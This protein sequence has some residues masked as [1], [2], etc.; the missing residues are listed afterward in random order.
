MNGRGNWG[1]RLAFAAAWQNVIFHPP[2]LAPLLRTL[3]FGVVLNCPHSRMSPAFCHLPEPIT[4][5]SQLAPLRAQ[6]RL[7][8]GSAFVS[9]QPT[10]DLSSTAHHSTVLPSNTTAVVNNNNN[11]NC[12]TSPTNESSTAPT[13]A[14]STTTAADALTSELKTRLAWVSLLMVFQPFHEQFGA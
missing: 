6:N 5:P 9:T 4:S 12:R 2:N 1:G 13:I 14:I 10:G 11:T 8:N 3:H 7:V